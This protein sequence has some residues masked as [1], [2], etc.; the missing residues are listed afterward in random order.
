VTCGDR[1]ALRPE[2]PVR[3]RLP[4]LPD[5]VTCAFEFDAETLAM[6]DAHL[7]RTDD[8]IFVTTTA[9]FSAVLLPRPECPPMIEVSGFDGLKM[10]ETREIEVAAFAP[11]RD[12]GKKH[13]VQVDI[14]GLMDA[15]QGVTLPA[16]ATVVVPATALPGQYKLTVSGDCLPLKRW[17]CL[18]P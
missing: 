8:G 6:H 17:I 4:E 3:V 1:A 11:W 14:P 18:K 16:K 9:G 13:S 10:N 15:P 7:E 12:E 2:K 5:D